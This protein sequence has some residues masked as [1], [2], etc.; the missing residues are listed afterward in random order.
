MFERQLD[1]WRGSGE[2]ICELSAGILAIV[3]L[4]TI[5]E[6]AL[7]LHDPATETDPSAY[8]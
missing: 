5:T 2:K 8:S 3:S 6:K 4:A 1:S 7:S